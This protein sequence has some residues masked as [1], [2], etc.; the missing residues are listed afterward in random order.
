[1]NKDVE[2]AFAGRDDLLEEKLSGLGIDV[3]KGLSYAGNDWN[4]YL[5]ILNCF[6]EEYDAKRE[7]FY[8]YQKI[9]LKTIILKPL[10]I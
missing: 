10:P 6:M 4:F 3:S 8:T 7:L 2:P 9:S 5:E 1:M